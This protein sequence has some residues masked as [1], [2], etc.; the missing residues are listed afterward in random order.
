MLDQKVHTLEKNVVKARQLPQLPGMTP[1]EEGVAGRWYPGRTAALLL[2]YG[3]TF[4]VLLSGHV[5][6]TFAIATHHA[7]PGCGTTRAASALLHGDLA[8]AFHYNP[9]GP[10]VMAALLVVAAE[11]A[12]RVARYG[13]VQDLGTQGPS[14]FAVR[15]LFVALV[16]QIVVW[17]ARFFGFFGGPVPVE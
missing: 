4:L 6:C 3:L 1:A 10:V 13:N 14:H 9:M 8:Q 12:F 16:L 15:V 5:K 11:S 2:G 7:C 17:I